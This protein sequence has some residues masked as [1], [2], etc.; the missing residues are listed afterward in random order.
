MAVAL[1][2]NVNSFH[3]E[4]TPCSLMEGCPDDQAE[5]VDRARRLARLGGIASLLHSIY[6][7]R[8]SFW[9]MLCTKYQLR[10][11]D[12]STIGVGIAVAQNS[13]AWAKLEEAEKWLERVD[14]LLS[15]LTPEQKV[16]IN[17]ADPTA[18]ESLRETYCSI[19]QNKNMFLQKYMQT[20]WLKRKMLWGDIYQD[21]D[22]LMMASVELHLD[23]LVCRSSNNPRLLIPGRNWSRPCLGTVRDG[24]R[25]K[26]EKAHAWLDLLDV[27]NFVSGCQLGKRRAASRVFPCSDE[28][29]RDCRPPAVRSPS[30]LALSSVVVEK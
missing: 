29:Q 5:F 8:P 14:K 24:K 6:F 11:L 13:T 18:L 16:I 21:A 9:R 17:A 15:H 28:E 3:S 20:G 25:G 4:S 23:A 22:E 19:S 27:V 10:V 1:N 30:P 12:C 2:Y 7:S 26:E